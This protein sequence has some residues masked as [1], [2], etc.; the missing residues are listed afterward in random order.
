MKKTLVFFVLLVASFACSGQSDPSKVLKKSKSEVLL[1]FLNQN[2]DYHESFYLNK[3]YQEDKLSIRFQ[4]NYKRRLRFYKMADS[5]CENSTDT[6]Q[7]R[8][9]CP[10]AF[11]AKIYENLLSKDDLEYLA[12]AFDN[13]SEQIKRID[14]KTVSDNSSPLV[15]EH[16]EQFYID[17]KNGRKIIEQKELPSLLIKGIYLSKNEKVA[18]M[19]FIYYSHNTYTRTRYAILKKEDKVWWRLLGTLSR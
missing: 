13:K 3:I 6:L 19:A 14:V 16:S 8:L 4:E 10:A 9:Y 17:Y 15:L 11:S 18:I 7:L 5:I 2:Y 1:A 12:S